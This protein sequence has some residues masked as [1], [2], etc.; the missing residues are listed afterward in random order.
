MKKVLLVA[1]LVAFGVA[2]TA[3][4]EEAAKAEAMVTVKGVVVVVKEADAVKTVGIKKAEG[5]VVNVVLDEQGKKL[6]AA[7]GKAVVAGGTMK[8]KDLVV[9]SFKVAE[10]K[11]P[12]AA[13]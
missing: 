8:E 5:E 7:D 10:E 4:A 1:A 9:K 3:M 13:K 6:A 2:V 11:A 12:E